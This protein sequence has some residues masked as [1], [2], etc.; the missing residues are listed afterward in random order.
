MIGVE[1]A[2]STGLGG[3]WAVSENDIISHLMPSEEMIS[4]DFIHKKANLMISQ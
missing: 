3:G 2:S 4:H 1:G